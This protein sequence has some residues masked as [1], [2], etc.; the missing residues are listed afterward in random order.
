MVAPDAH[1]IDRRRLFGAQ[2]VDVLVESCRQS[3][4][5]RK[6]IPGT[7]RY[8]SDANRAR[9]ARRR[10][11]VDDFIQRAIAAGRDNVIAACVN[12][13]AREN[14]RVARLVC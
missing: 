10:N 1:Q 4:R 9:A 3:E 2:N 14:F 12:R 7:E 11:S 13:L 5:P 6:I 8:N